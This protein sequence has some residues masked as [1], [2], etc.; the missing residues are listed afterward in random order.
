LVRDL[1]SNINIL[2]EGKNFTENRYSDFC[3]KFENKTLSLDEA[4]NLLQLMVKSS[5]VN[6][7]VSPMQ[8]I[9][10]DYCY[11]LDQLRLD[12]ESRNKYSIRFGEARNMQ[13]ELII[14]KI[15][16]MNNIQFDFNNGMV[17]N[18]L[19]DPQLV[20]DIL[21]GKK[22]RTENAET[23]EAEFIREIKGKMRNT[24]RDVVKLDSRP[25]NKSCGDSTRSESISFGVKS[26]LA[27]T[28]PYS[29]QIR[30]TPISSLSSDTTLKKE[31]FSDTPSVE[32]HPR[33]HMVDDMVNHK[34]NS[35]WGANSKSIRDSNNSLVGT[36][37]NKTPNK[38][39]NQ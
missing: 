18:P 34:Y 27:D 38:G 5:G 39:E 30:T 29:G 24:Y 19:L 2:V 10:A 22:V 13:L 26:K 14:D 32:D 36:K 1:D 4:G 35:P 37:L 7:N 31:Y 3:A 33:L 16:F 17:I 28:K 25:V 23:K 8:E 20:A 11:V 9:A 21:R 15:N 6:N 12:I